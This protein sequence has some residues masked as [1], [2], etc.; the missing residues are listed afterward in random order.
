MCPSMPRTPDVFYSVKHHALMLRCRLSFTALYFWLPELVALKYRETVSIAL[1]LG[2]SHHISI[3]SLCMLNECLALIYL[4]QFAMKQFFHS[5]GAY[6]LAFVQE[7]GSYGMAM[8]S[9]VTAYINDHCSC[10]LPHVFLT[11]ACTSF[12][13]RLI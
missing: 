7:E 9:K 2:Y 1:A 8:E 4:M 6:Q 10:Y 11:L 5:D 12:R 3:P 13:S